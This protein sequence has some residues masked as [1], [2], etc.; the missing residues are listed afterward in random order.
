MG[1][2]ATL[3]FN[4]FTEQDIRATLNKACDGV[5]SI[6]GW[7]ASKKYISRKPR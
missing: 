7:G 1:S 2:I 3:F 5:T 6:Q 4:E